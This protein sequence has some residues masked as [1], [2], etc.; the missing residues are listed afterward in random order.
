MWLL[1]VFYLHHVFRVHL[2][3]SVYQCVLFMAN[4]TALYGV[5]CLPVRQLMDHFGRFLFLAIVL[6]L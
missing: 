4:D 3:W 2:C 6:L 5:F 1:C